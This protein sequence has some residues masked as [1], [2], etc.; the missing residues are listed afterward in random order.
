MASPVDC[1]EEILFCQV[2]FEE[3]KEDG[4]HVPRLLPC[5][6]TL[7]HTCI[8][9]LIQGNK[10]ECPECRQ[11]HE[12]KKE[13]KS[14]P[15]NKY[16]IVQI[17]RRSPALQKDQ[18]QSE[19]CLEHGKELNIFCKDAGC[20][21][22]IC[23]ACSS[24]Y[25]QKHNFVGIEERKKEVI[26]VLQRNIKA[27]ITN[28]QTKVAKVAAARVTVAKKMNLI[29]LKIKKEEMTKQYD[30]M[31]KE[32]EDQIEIINVKTDQDLDAMNENLNLLKDISKN[33][34][35]TKENSYSDLM[36]KLDTV[37]GITE[38]VNKNLTGTRTFQYTSN[39]KTKAVKKRITIEINEE[40]VEEGL[41]TN[42][43]SQDRSKQCA[44]EQ[45]KPVTL[46]G[47]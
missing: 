20:Q 33:T 7:C 35:A 9:Q 31:I 6:H 14:F 39:I 4:D 25:H 2:C 5:S 11:K 47:K 17:K 23:V 46:C 41:R 21:K 16:I 38:N 10:I 19:Q 29:Q 26:G 27:A 24:S 40:I 30:R 32:A 34:K 44:E 18:T 12:A 45:I 8:G 15:Q 3:F 42:L 28:L 43:A 22:T 37:R 1:L 13:E 36:N